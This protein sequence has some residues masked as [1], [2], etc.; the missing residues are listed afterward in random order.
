MSHLEMIEL[1]DILRAHCH[2]TEDGLAEY[3]AEYSDQRIADESNGKYTVFNVSG[4]RA[5]LIGKLK[6][7]SRMTSGSV[8]DRFKYL[9]GK[10]AA[11]Q[12]VIEHLVSWAG[13]RTRE[14]YKTK[15]EL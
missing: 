10:I 3:E 11:Q 1:V 5:N 12:R 13:R 4:L 9:E 8:E 6:K 7:Y 15:W 14:P 2:K